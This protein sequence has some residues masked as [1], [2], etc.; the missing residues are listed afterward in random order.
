ML[1]FAGVVGR[2]QSPHKVFKMLKY[3]VTLLAICLFTFLGQASAAAPVKGYGPWKLGMSK[4]AV[5]ALAK[6]GPY[7]EVPESGGVETPNGEFDGAKSNVS[8]IFSEAKL[9]KIQVWAYEGKDLQQAIAAWYRVYKYLAKAY[10][11]AKMP[12]EKYPESIQ[13]AAIE[14]MVKSRLASVPAA[15]QVKLQMAPQNMPKDMKVFSSF[16]RHPTH[17]YFVFLYFQEP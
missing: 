2:I 4:P 17:G 11:P 7:K 3:K 1:S 6:F 12:T 13:L 15:K 14:N 8:L 16:I 5:L 9:K 10:D